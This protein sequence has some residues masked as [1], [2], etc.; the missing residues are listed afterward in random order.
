MMI[1]VLQR[2]P[3]QGTAVDLGDWWCL[4]KIEG[5]RCR[6][7]VCR[8]FSHEFGWELRLEI[9]GDQIRTGLCRDQDSVFTTFESWKAALCE[10]GWQ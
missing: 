1:Q 8:M 3:W 5:C 7:A 4:H 10:A 6:R 2:L 9:D